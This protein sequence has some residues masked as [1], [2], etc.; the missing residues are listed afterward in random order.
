MRRTAP[1]SREE[2]VSPRPR[3]PTQERRL[4]SLKPP[5]PSHALRTSR[6]ASARANPAMGERCSKASAACPKPRQITYVAQAKIYVIYTR[7]NE[8]ALR[9][10]QARQ[11][12]G[13]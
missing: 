8:R 2:G 5:S 12:R 11:D 7:M 9:L 10:R 6:P 13:Y 3:A 4:G 1:I